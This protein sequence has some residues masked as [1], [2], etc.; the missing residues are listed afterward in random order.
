[1]SEQHPTFDNTVDVDEYFGY[2]AEGIVGT[3]F[4]SDAGLTHQYYEGRLVVDDIRPARDDEDGDMTLFVTNGGRGDTLSLHE[5][6]VGL[7]DG[8]HRIIEKEN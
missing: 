6:F 7:I 3:R 8:E 2:D 4:E 1:M 5:F